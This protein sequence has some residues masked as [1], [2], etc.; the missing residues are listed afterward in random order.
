MHVSTAYANCHLRRIEEKFYHYQVK[1]E[2][3]EQMMAKLDDKEIA[4]LTPS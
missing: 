2:E 3:L 4:K 1:Y